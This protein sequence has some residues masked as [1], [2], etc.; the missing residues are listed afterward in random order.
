MYTGWFPTEDL[1]GLGI[2]SND[3]YYPLEGQWSPTSN[4]PSYGHDLYSPTNFTEYN[5][6]DLRRRQIPSEISFEDYLDI[7]A[8]EFADEAS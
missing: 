2:S 4:F 8:D 7:Y 6:T 1:P 5:V 3:G